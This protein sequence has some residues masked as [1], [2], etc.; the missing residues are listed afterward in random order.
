MIKNIGKKI[1]FGDFI[2]ETNKRLYR[3]CHGFRLTKRRDYF[4]IL[5]VTFDYFFRLLIEAAAKIS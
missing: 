2:S 4:I 1:K 3:E 5:L